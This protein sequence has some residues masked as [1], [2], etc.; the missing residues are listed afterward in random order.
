MKQQNWEDQ[1]TSYAFRKINLALVERV[2][3]HLSMLHSAPTFILTMI[4]ELT[5][6]MWQT[7]VSYPMKGGMA[8]LCNQA[9]Q[10]VV[11]LAKWDPFTNLRMVLVAQTK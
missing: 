3:K 9:A 5:K 10:L 1:L 11:R 6:V 4:R 2:L 8:T 7:L